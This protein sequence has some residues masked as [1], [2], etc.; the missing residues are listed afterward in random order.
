MYIQKQI[1]QNLTLVSNNLKETNLKENKTQYLM[2][3]WTQKK[4]MVEFD[5]SFG[6]RYTHTCAR[7]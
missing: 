6:I 4:W 2:D 5:I 1:C 7:N 3:G